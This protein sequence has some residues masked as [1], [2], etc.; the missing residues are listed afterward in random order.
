MSGEEISVTSPSGI[1]SSNG[2][3]GWV[4]RQ[5]VISRDGAALLGCDVALVVVVVEGVEVRPR[6]VECGSTMRLPRCRSA[7]SVL[8]PLVACRPALLLRLLNMKFRG[9]SPDMA[10][11]DNGFLGEIPPGPP[12]IPMLG[13]RSGAFCGNDTSSAPLLVWRVEAL[14]GGDVEGEAAGGSEEVVHS[15]LAP[16]FDAG[17][18]AVRERRSFDAPCGPTN[19]DGVGRSPF[20][21]AP[22]LGPLL[23]APDT[24]GG[25]KE[26]G[27]AL[28]SPPTRALVSSPTP[29]GLPEGVTARSRV[30]APTPRLG[31]RLVLLVPATGEEV[32]TVGV[33]RGSPD[34][35][36]YGEA[37]RGGVRTPAEFAV[38]LGS[39][40]WAVLAGERRESGLPFLP[41]RDRLPVLTPPLLPGGITGLHVVGLLSTV[42]S[43]RRLL[44]IV[45]G[46][47]SP[48]GERRGI[49]TDVEGIGSCC[50]LA[51]LEN[52]ESSVGSTVLDVVVLVSPPLGEK[53]SLFLLSFMRVEV[54]VVLSF[55]LCVG[56]VAIGGVEV[57]SLASQVVSRPPSLLP[58]ALGPSA[59]VVVSE[60]VA[61][62]AVF[63]LRKYCGKRSCMSCSLSR[64]AGLE[65]IFFFTDFFFCP[66]R[67]K[68]NK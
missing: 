60:V 32:R 48:A 7:P 8:P 28:R 39:V 21:I 23:S 31:V 68:K 37:G 29:A 61:R 62:S 14:V 25:R 36:Q 59:E 18:P 38:V 56:E 51:V 46:E 34:L 65:V 50:L 55:A 42:S 43:R 5:A 45:K 30:R 54:S 47:C 10:L 13:L 41:P 53:I 12:S 2:R 19:V 24:E 3:D 57:G 4:P 11:M 6:F 35:G 33:V 20:P 63:F 26:R 64:L 40:L 22:P 66:T 9:L 27:A 67:K 1:S 49:E 17:R 16:P 58:S 52:G 15:F 44:L